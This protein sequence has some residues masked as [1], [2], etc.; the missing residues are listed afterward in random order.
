M[1]LRILRN[2][3]LSAA[4]SLVALAGFAQGNIVSAGA[5]ASFSAVY[6]IQAAEN[7]FSFTGNS[8]TANTFITITVD[9]AFEISTAALGPYAGSITSIQANAS[10]SIPSTTIYVRIKEGTIPGAYNGRTILFF[11]SLGVQRFVKGIQNSSVSVR[12]IDVINVAIATKT[13]DG[14]TSASIISDG[15]G[16]ISVNNIRTAD[17]SNVTLVT[18]GATATFIDANAGTS[19]VT[20]ISGYTITG[21]ASGYYSLNQPSGI[22]GD[23]DP[24]P[25]AINAIQANKTY[26]TALTSGS[27]FTGFNAVGVVG[28]ENPGTVTVT[29]SA[30]AA[31]NANVG[32]YTNSI[33]L[34]ALTGGSGGFDA[35]NYTITYN[36]A[37]IV[38]NPKVL[39]LSGVDAND[40]VYNGNTVAILNGGVSLVGGIESGDDC[41]LDATGATGTFASP[42]V[43][44]G[45]NVTI[46]GYTL[47]GA[48]AGNYSLTQPSSVSKNITAKALTI[49]ANTINKPYGD[50]LTTG[51][52]KT[53]FTSSG[54]VAGETIASVTLT[55]G[56]GA[57]GTDPVAATYVGGIVASAPVA[58]V[59]F[60]ATNYAITYTAGDLTVAPKSLT[61]TATPVN[62]TY[63]TALTSGAGYSGFNAVGL[64]SGEVAGTVTVTYGTGSAANANVGTY[65]NAVALSAL[66]GGSGGFNASNYSI[67][68][69][70]AN[71][72]VGAKTLTLSGAGV[73]NKVY[74]GNTNDTLTNVTSGVV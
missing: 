45:I 44:N 13:Y 9:P 29:Y 38:V 49:T 10:G 42:N 17:L 53:A 72:V 52:G 73:S 46:S 43:A 60:I 66:T 36:N 6:G 74:D 19:K 8:F 23:I 54:L 70:D 31:S 67:S 50:V 34:S 30:G 12:N 22:F 35:N 47:V 71:I 68:Y 32:T 27:G 15:V 14:N 39:T 2:F 37:N 65:N 58:G 3:L 25:L 20:T 5:V 33:V 63:G 59:G 51:P 56:T 7:S 40:K 57:A 41:T 62:K 11:N 26:G 48:Q 21:S 64:V 28:A 4:F 69:A 55:Y 16:P 1:R 24:K 61:I 18:S